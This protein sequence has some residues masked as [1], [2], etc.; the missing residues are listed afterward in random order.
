MESAP[1]IDIALSEDPVH[2]TP[3][4]PFPQPAGAECVF[5]GRTRDET[6]D[7]HGRLIRL[8]YEAYPSMAERVLREIAEE[9]AAKFGC[10][11]V[12]VHHAIGDVPPG[13]ASVVV[14][15]V[16]GHRAESFDACRYVID[17]LKR[18]APIWKREEWADGSTWS[19]G[20]PIEPVAD[21]QEIETR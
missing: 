18:R 11:A 14:Q 19:D 5:F 10:L 4:V 6:H 8:S 21:R 3:F 17:H 2:V 20:A 15:V 13:D 1:L 12:R 7:V 9:A 16:A